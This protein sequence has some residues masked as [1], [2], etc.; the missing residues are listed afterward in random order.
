MTYIP[1]YLKT[2]PNMD[3]SSPI[4]ISQNRLYHG[5]RPHRHDFL[6]FSYVIDGRGSETINEIRHEML[7]GTFT[8]VLPYQVHELFTEPGSTLVL[9][10]CNFSMDLLM[11][12]GQEEALMDLIGQ[13]T[14]PPFFHMQGKD[15]ERMLA[16]I[17]DMYK[18]YKGQ[19]PWR[20]TMLQIRLKEILACFDRCRRKTAP[21][22][23]AAP[24]SV[25]KSGTAIWPVIQHIHRH[26]R[27]ELALSDLAL[28]FSISASR[29]SELIKQTTGQTFVHFVNDLRLRHACS[30]LVSTDMSVAD[31]A[32]E[33]GYGS[34]KTFSRIFRESK[35]LVP[36]DY[37]K[38]KQQK[39]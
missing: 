39:Q 15:Q 36:R 19:E 9:Y 12:S 30:L 28:Q 26:Y 20:E 7:P 4:Y 1:A 8:F 24:S 5:Y 21:A 25:G 13:D 16:L 23:V 33:A 10:N 32:M 2:Y 3:T 6:E 37:R 18:E 27:D 14:L 17:E 38:Q 29:L 22:P 31:I 11:A 35:G 34:Y